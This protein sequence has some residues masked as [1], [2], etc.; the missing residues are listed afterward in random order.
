MVW[1]VAQ[2][3]FVAGST[4]SWRPCEAALEDEN[5]PVL[6]PMPQGHCE[7]PDAATAK[8]TRSGH[9]ALACATCR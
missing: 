4:R 9:E 2:A 5:E 1:E 7:P 3:H 8:G 6:E